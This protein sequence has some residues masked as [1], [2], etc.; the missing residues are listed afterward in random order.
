VQPVTGDEGSKIDKPEDPVL[1]GYTFLGWYT[2]LEGGELFT[3]W[4]HTVTC[5]LTL[6]AQW[7]NNR[8]APIAEYTITF[9][10]AGGTDVSDIEA[11]AW[12]LVGK[13]GDPEK[14]GYT[15]L[16]WYNAAEGGELYE[17]PITLARDLTLYAQWTVNKYTIAFDSQG[18]S[19]LSAA[20]GSA[21]TLIEEPADPSL[22]GYIFLG[23]YSEPEGGELYE[24]PITLARD[25]TLYA[26]WSGIIYTVEYDGNGEDGGTESTAATSHV[27]GVESPLAENGFTKAGHIFGGWNTQAD[28]LGLNYAALG[29]VTDL[30]SEAGGKLTLYARWYKDTESI[31][32][33]NFDTQGGPVVNFIRANMWDPL[34]KPGDPARRAYNFEGWYDARSGGT[35]Y[36]W[37]HTVTCNLMMY[38][39]WTPVTYTITYHLNGGSNAA[40]NPASYTCESQAAMEPPSRTGYAFG[41]WYANEQLTGSA[42]AS[43]SAGNAGDKSYWAKWTPVSY[44]ITYNLN[45]GSN[46]PGSPQS[47]TIENGLTL[48]EPARTGYAFSGWFGAEWIKLDE[49][50]VAYIPPGSLGDK[51]FWATWTPAVYTVT[52]NLNGGSNPPGSPQSYTIESGLTLPEPVRTNYA[53]SGWFESKDFTGSASGSIPKG[54]LAASSLAASS[55]AASSLG[56]KTFWAKW[57]ALYT[58]KYNANGGSG[59]TP[60]SIHKL[61]EE[62][63]MAA[64]GF[65]RSGYIFSGWNT[66][67]DGSGTNYKA[68]SRAANAASEAG[69]VVTL[70]ARWLPGSMTIELDNPNRSIGGELDAKGRMTNV[71]WQFFPERKEYVI[72]SGGES[73]DTQPVYV[74][75]RTQVNRIRVVP[76]KNENNWANVPNY[77]ESGAYQFEKWDGSWLFPNDGVPGYSSGMRIPE[78]KLLGQIYNAHMIRIIFVNAEIDIPY[79]QGENSRSPLDIG[80]YH[81]FWGD[82]SF[83]GD[84]YDS[85]RGAYEP[86]DHEVDAVVEFEGKNTL[87]T[88]Y[89]PSITLWDSHAV[90]WQYVNEIP[91]QP[92]SDSYDSWD[93]AHNRPHWDR[94]AEKCLK[95]AQK[96]GYWQ[97]DGVKAKF[98]GFGWGPSALTVKFRGGGILTASNG[99]DTYNVVEAGG[100]DITLP[101]AAS[102]NIAWARRMTF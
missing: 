25:L 35:K 30:T 98:N 7:H 58:V 20:N 34:G 76:G 83:E 74:T 64:G 21:G 28:G 32:T 80:P 29:N 79:A 17:W 43:I 47:Y 78:L 63:V 26:Q 93:T 51:T 72:Y 6:Y 9:D 70:Y 55:L 45:G 22:E 3:A 97:Y 75:G 99:A 60:Q 39:Q 101:D 40:E 2:E 102:N 50:S 77:K 90:G 81:A 73:Y 23:W 85:Q 19:E 31:Y 48:P 91:W 52:Y 87:Y 41:G 100:A 46:P 12:S 4:P 16:G 68:A 18:G 11:F 84:F 42:A 8:A 56:D 89:R 15:F 1:K 66:R 67:S 59:S 37:P 71:R 10:S 69:E 82:G 88:P 14:E 62:N 61:G 86:N 57:T 95:F 54:G 38:A 65:S 53:F 96:W 24:W 44:T 36:E 13:P 5:D 49:R 33:I 94:Y 92:D 27:Y